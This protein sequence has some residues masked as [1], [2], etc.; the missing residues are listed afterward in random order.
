MQVVTPE[1]IHGREKQ[2]F[3]TEDG[4]S[5]VTQYFNDRGPDNE[6]ASA[7]LV[8][9]RPLP[10]QAIRPHFHK[11]AQFQVVIGG[12]GQIGKVPVPPISFQ[13]ADPSTPYGP[14]KPADEQRGIDFLT[15]RPVSR[16]GLWWM[17][18]NNHELEGELRRNRAN[19]VPAD[20]PLPASGAERQ[21]MIERDDD[22]LA[23]YLVRLA[24]GAEEV[25]EV[26]GNSWGQYHLITRG[27]VVD[28]D[29]RELERMT[30]LYTG[31]GESVSFT[32][33]EDGGEVLV[34]QFPR[35][36]EPATEEA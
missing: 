8:E 17:P 11:V 24:P 18:G 1:E 20:A 16:A 4:L 29:G 6:D 21:E 15:L 13:Y 31:R 12:D 9:Y 34:M 19:T 22:G 30:L 26:P 14:I 10:R 2:E 5:R 25:V 28:Q 33:G 35:G 23:G 27:S 7:F 32:A 36:I 3:N